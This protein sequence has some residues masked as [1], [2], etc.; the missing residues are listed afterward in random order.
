MATADDIEAG[1]YRYPDLEA[2][3]YVSSRSDLHDKQKKLGFPYPVK[4]SPKVALF[5]K[6]EV[7]AW[8]LDILARRDA[9]HRNACKQIEMAQAAEIDAERHARLIS[10]TTETDAR[11]DDK[12]RKGIQRQGTTVDK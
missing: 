8:W 5:L 11:R 3:K 9:E 4:P 12:P 2:K 6:S 10:Q 1:F 7:H